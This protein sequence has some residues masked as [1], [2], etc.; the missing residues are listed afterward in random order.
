[1]VL[2]SLNEE[3]I[4]EDF[5]NNLSL[6]SQLIVDKFDLLVVGS[7]ILDEMEKEMIFKV[8]IYYNNWILKVVKLLGFIRSVLYW[9]LE[10]YQIFY[11]NE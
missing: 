3:L 8:M 4:V 10:K 1:M 11:N 9:R 6:M 7:I 5:I 2:I